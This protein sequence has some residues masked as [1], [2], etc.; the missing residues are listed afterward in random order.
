M[1]LTYML[2]NLALPVYVIRYQR[3]DLDL[4]RHLILPIV[5]TAI[6]LLPLWG[7][8]QPDQSWPLNSFPWIVLGAL[9]LSASYGVILARSSPDLA[10]RIGAYVAD[11]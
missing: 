11:Q 6:M 3:A 4:T 8:V 7:L 1:I 10:Q 9:V 5:G 2:T